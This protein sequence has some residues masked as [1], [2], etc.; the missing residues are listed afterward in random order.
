MSAPEHKVDVREWLRRALEDIR[1]AHYAYEGHFLLQACF[2]CQQAAEKALKALLLAYNQPLERTHSLPRLLELCEPFVP[3]LNQFGDSLT[4]LDV[5]YAP[6]RYADVAHEI[7]YTEERVLDALA[8]A[9]EVVQFLQQR[10]EA[11]LE[12]R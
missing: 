10:I 1:W 5:Y 7:D 3:D 4:V 6:T 9:E 2:G 8:R 11:R 12:E